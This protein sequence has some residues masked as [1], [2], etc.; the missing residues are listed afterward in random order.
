MGGSSN[1]YGGGYFGPAIPQ[2]DGNS[3][4][5]CLNLVFE[6]TLAS[7]DVTVLATVNVGDTLTVGVASPIGPVIVLK[8]EKR[9]GTVLSEY[10]VLLLQCISEGTIYNAKVIKID[11]P[12]C[13]VKI[14]PI[15]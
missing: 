13:V 11:S 15:R 10:D 8:N 12:E 6:T 9:V 4:D 3:Q 2:S 1:G 14:Y 5:Q 7:V